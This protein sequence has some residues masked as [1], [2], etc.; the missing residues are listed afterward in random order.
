MYSAVGDSTPEATSWVELGRFKTSTVTWTRSSYR[1]AAAGANARF[2]IRYNVVGGGPNGANSD[3]MGVDYLT[4]ATGGGGPVGCTYNFTPQTT[5]LLISFSQFQQSPIRSD[6]LQVLRPT[7][8][9]T[10]NGGVTWSSATGTG[11]TGDVHLYAWSAND[12]LCTTS[13]SATNI[14]RP[15]TAEQPGH[16]YIRKQVDSLMRFK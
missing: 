6:G 16:W 7:V 9:R 13:P 2:A 14:Y 5:V 4:V 3:Y 1:T 15:Q 11:I 12:A 8:V 10:V